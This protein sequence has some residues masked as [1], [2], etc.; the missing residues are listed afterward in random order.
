MARIVIG[1]DSASPDLIC[2]DGPRANHG[3]DQ[4]MAWVAPASKPLSPYFQRMMGLIVVA[5]PANDQLVA[6]VD[7]KACPLKSLRDDVI[8]GRTAQAISDHG[9]AAVRAR[10]TV[11]TGIL[12]LGRQGHRRRPFL[13][14][15]LGERGAWFW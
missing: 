11:E 8:A 6:G 10:A 2:K 14:P 12:H 3:E 5:L 15:G 4:Q 13:N 9:I 7:L 1:V